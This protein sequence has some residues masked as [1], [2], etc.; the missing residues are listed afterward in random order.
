LTGL[1]GEYIK[2]FAELNG[3]ETLGIFESPVHR[4]KGN[5]EYF[6]YLGRHVNG[7]S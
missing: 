4:Q 2:T 6:I 7:K 1:A 5:I 3:L